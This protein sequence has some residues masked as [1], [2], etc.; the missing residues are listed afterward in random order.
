MNILF[1]SHYYPPEGNA[2]ASRVAALAERWVAAGHS[3]TV[4]TCAPNVPNGIVYKGYRNRWCARETVN[5]VDVVRVWTY[6][7]ANRGAVRRMFN[8]VSY[9]FSALWR[10][11]R[12]PRPDVAIAT[13]PQIFCGYA[14]VWVKRLRRI[15]L[16]ME[17]RDIWPE[18]MAAV[19]ARVPSPAIWAL[20]GIERSLYRVCDRIV[21]VGEGYRD[22]LVEKG[23]PA[24]RISIVMNGTDP[25]LF[26]PRPKDE[27]LLSRHGLSGKFVVSYVGTVG[28]ACGLEVVLDAAAMLAAETRAP[29]M[30]EIVFAIVG[31][32]ACRE[33]LESDARRR[34]LVNVVFTGRRPK[35]EM[36]AWI[37]SSDANL[38]HLRRSGLFTTVMPSKI[39]ESAGCAR[40]VIM[41]VDGYAKKLV[42]DAEAGLDMK[43]EDAGSLVDCARRLASDRALCERLGANALERIG[44]V[45]S[46]DR[47]AQDYLELLSKLTAR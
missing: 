13:S 26:F 47:Q 38:V 9:F 10:T 5:G 1:L 15:P 23:V 33:Q 42:L 2:P 24:D 22:R 18:S 37:A 28:M 14:G 39:F 16:V 43:P 17:I 12:L 45:H 44:R 19:G 36:P 4:V 27:D 25:S 40:P 29:G 46:R 34:G 8:F 11:L 30:P 3:V 7:A 20:E 6:L 41:G 35:S 31:D 21:T 32:G